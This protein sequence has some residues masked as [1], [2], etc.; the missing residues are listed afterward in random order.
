MPPG[1]PNPN[2]NPNPERVG[3][4]P[5]PHYADMRLSPPLTELLF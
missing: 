2:P 3:D 1:H 4:G 5:N